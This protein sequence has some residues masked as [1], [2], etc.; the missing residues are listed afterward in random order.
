MVGSTDPSTYDFYM[1]ADSDSF[2]RMAALS[3][4]WRHLKPN[5]DP[6]KEQIVWGHHLGHNRHWTPSSEAKF[7]A[8]FTLEDE[9]REGQGY[10]YTVGIAYLF[11][12]MISTSRRYPRH[13]TS[14]QFPGC[15]K[16]H[17]S[18][19]GSSASYSIS[20]RRRHAGL[21]DL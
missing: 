4:R 20:V 14:A 5:T 18:Q 19:R 16:A 2:L 10:H 6:R 9:W 13:L 7:A 1:G 17:R 11:R 12:Y 8:N 15:R 21:L 3:R